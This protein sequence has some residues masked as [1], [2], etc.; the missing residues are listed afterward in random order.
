MM[1][2]LNEHAQAVNNTLE[3]ALEDA[4]VPAGTAQEIVWT[5]HAF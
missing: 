4:G 1:N 3:G 5:C 2:D